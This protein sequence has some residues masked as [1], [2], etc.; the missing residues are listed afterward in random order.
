MDGMPLQRVHSPFL[1]VENTQKQVT[2]STPGI[3]GL[4]SIIPPAALF[5]GYAFE[6]AAEQFPEK[7]AL[8]WQFVRPFGTTNFE[9]GVNR[10]GQCF[11]NADRK[12]FLCRHV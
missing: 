9:K 6:T 2:I 8:R 5:G 3:N 10:E 4:I 11:R 12:R 7:R 1:I